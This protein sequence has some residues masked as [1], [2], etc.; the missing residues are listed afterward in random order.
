MA[1]SSILHARQ[2]AGLTVSLL[3][4]WMLGGSVAFSQVNLD[5]IVERGLRSKNGPARIV[6]SLRFGTRGTTLF[7]FALS[8]KDS[9]VLYL[10]SKMGFVFGTDD[11]GTTWKEGRL[12]SRRS[13]FFGSI[14]PSIAP[15]GAPFS[16]QGNLNG[17]QSRGFLKNSLSDS[18]SFP[19]KTTNYQLLDFQPDD[20]VYWSGLR[21]SFFPQTGDQKVRDSSGGGGGGDAARLGV[22]LKMSAKRLGGLLRKRKKKPAGMN[23]QLL[24]T[25]RGSEPTGVRRLAIHPENPNIAFAAT[26][27]GLYR[28]VDGGYSWLNAYPGRN[29]SER[30]CYFVIF[31]PTESNRIFLGT[32]Q[33]LL[34]SNDGGM[35]FNR[36]SGTQ[37]SSVRTLWLEFHPS[38]PQIIYAG[39]NVGAFRTDDGGENWRWIFFETL[40]AANY[41]TSIAVDP[42]DADRVTLGTYDGLF[43]TRDG[44]VTWD[45]SGPLLFTSIAVDRVIADPLDSNHVIVMT[46]YRV[47]ETFDWGETWQSMYLDDGE[48]SPRSIQFDPGDPTVF[49]LLTSHELFRV[50]K[51]SSVDLEVIGEDVVRAIYKREPRLSTVMDAVFRHFGVHRGERSALRRKGQTRWILPRVNVFSGVM[52]SY[53]SANLKPTYLTGLSFQN[54]HVLTRKIGKDQP[55]AGVMLNWDLKSLIFDMEELSFGRVFAKS[56][57]AY[58]SLK[59]ETNRLFEERKRLIAKMVFEKA[60]SRMEDEARKLRLNELTSHLNALSGGLYESA[61]DAIERDTFFTKGE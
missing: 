8:K 17:L 43:R 7:D 42:N 14:R 15:S 49:W 26:Q 21:S 56:N 40:Q 54:N 52:N 16:A 38:N 55:Y 1:T 13:P 33:G 10:G 9:N 22:G 45:R 28:T 36:V 61:V 41:I 31:H 51:A 60:G 24:L 47:W 3:F 46:Y 37:L 18:F 44:G 59:F 23:L 57:G 25:M 11:G 29:L 6:E 12:I 4:L 32:G 5:E 30:D 34:V 53:D 20:P 39:S 19:Y 48:F 35:K 27:M 2:Y 58:N 50:R